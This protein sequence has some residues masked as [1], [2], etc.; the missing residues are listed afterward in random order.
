MDLSSLRWRYYAASASVVVLV[1]VAYQYWQN[2]VDWGFV[3]GVVVVYLVLSIA[4][5]LVRG[6]GE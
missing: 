4:I 5:D 2:A 6:S 1:L 3:V